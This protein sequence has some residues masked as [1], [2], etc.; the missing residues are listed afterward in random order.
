MK[1][2]GHFIVVAAA[3][4]AC[5]ADWPMLG[6]TGDRN[7]VS[8][9]TNAPLDWR[10][11]TDTAPSRNIKWS[12]KVES[13]SRAIGGPV[14]SGG[15]VWVGCTDNDPDLKVDNAVLACFRVADGK[16]M[17]RH[18]SPRLPNFP[19][20]WPGQS[21]SGSPLI[22]GD[23]LWF[24][25]NRREVIC[26]DLAP[27]HNGTGLPREVW[28]VDMIARFKIHPRAIMIPGHDTHGSPA[29]HKDFLY[30][31]TGNSMGNAA[32]TVVDLKAPELV[33]LRKDSGKVVWT[34]N[35]P[36]KERMLGHYASPTVVSISGVA[37]VIHPQSDGWVR[38]F[39]AETGKL[40]WKFD[41]N[42]KTPSG[43]FNGG[44]LDTELN[45]VVAA[46]VH[47]NGRIYFATG[48]DPESN[49]AP[50]R[51][52]CIDPT[53]KGDISP[54]FIDD[55][56]Q[57]KNKPNPNSGV[58]WQFDGKDLKEAERMH[59]SMSSVA[60]HDG[61]VISADGYGVVHCLDEKTGKLY[62]VHVLKDPGHGN[63]LVVDGKIYVA[64]DS[65]D[66]H[67]LEFS[68]TKKLIAK[69]EMNTS[70]IAPPV[71]ANGVLYVLSNRSLTAIFQKR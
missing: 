25:N 62:W 9:E 1:G 34:D 27:L 32:V 50:G 28:K 20:D 59:L 66:V 71:F 33:C 55:T 53:K 67:I 10:I 65:G 44:D 16:L 15:Y 63:P 29:G 42:R 58:V 46:P 70:M 31:P 5:A 3:I 21:L 19:D 68:K 13:G 40:I 52:F 22:E 51:L 17:Y 60:I 45:S 61:L 6:R 49:Y 43:K 2:M 7:P 12:V 39:D 38:S 64:T 36:G 57:K 11:Q 14:V 23:R 54:E 18:V 26:L 37:Q 69:H 4:V 41:S 56:Q 35:S 47:A 24:C 30:V 48:R 8:L